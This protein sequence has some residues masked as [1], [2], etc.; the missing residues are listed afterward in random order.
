MI[1]ELLCKLYLARFMGKNDRYAQ[2][3]YAEEQGA[4]RGVAI[5]EAKQKFGL[6]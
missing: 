5:G 4:A 1:A 6:L 3:A 2:L